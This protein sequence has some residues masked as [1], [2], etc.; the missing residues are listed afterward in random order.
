M[1]HK[2]VWQHP[3]AAMLLEGPTLDVTDWVLDEEELQQEVEV[4]VQAPIT[5]NTT[6]TG[7]CLAA[8]ISAELCRAA[9]CR[10]SVPCFDTQSLWTYL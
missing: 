8:E 7:T 5:P 10:H 4:E 1:I 3:G 2:V 9:F 6:C